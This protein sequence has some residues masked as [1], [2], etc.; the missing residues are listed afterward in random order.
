MPERYVIVKI[1]DNTPRRIKY[2]LLKLLQGTTVTINNRRYRSRG[3]V[4]KYNGIKL[5]PR[6]YLIPFDKV[7]SFLKEV[8]LK[9]FDKYLETITTCIFS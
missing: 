7:E 4:D 9:G 5:C 3:L 2:R 8:S 6:T 1:S